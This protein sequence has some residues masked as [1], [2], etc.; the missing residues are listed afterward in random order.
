[1]KQKI[2]AQKIK[3]QKGGNREERVKV[4]CEKGH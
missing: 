4:V 2:N 1:M 3:E